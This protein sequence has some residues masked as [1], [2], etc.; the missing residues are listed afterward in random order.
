MLVALLGRHDLLLPLPALIV[1]CLF[2]ALLYQ[3]AVFGTEAPPASA[4]DDARA[5]QRGLLDRWLA[6]AR[7]TAEW[8]DGTEQEW[9]LHLRPMLA[10]EF[11]E[12]FHLHAQHDP[13]TYTS[14]GLALFGSTLWPWVDPREVAPARQASARP[15]PGRA[16]LTEILSRLER[17]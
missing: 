16:A 2:L 17:S 11:E 1:A 4:E 15:S 5:A 7:F 8:A 13:D 3:L 6:R 9:N 14:T 10:R 12:S